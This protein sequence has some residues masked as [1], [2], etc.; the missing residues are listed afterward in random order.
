MAG[1]LDGIRIL[2]FSQMMMGPW[3]TQLLGDLGADVIKVERP[4][5]GEWER[6]LAAM[7]ELLEGD[8]PFFLAMNRNKRS[9]TLNLKHPVARQVI[10][11]LIPEIDIVVENFRPGV[12]DR[13]GYGYERL[14]EINPRLIYCSASG[15]GS[16]GPYVDRPGQD[17]LIQALSGIAAHTGP[18]TEPPTPTGTS[19]CDAMASMMVSTGVLA[20]LQ[21]RERTGQGQKVEVD[22]LSTA[23]AIQCQEAVAYLNGMPRWERSAAGIAQ[24]WIAAPYGIYATSDSFLALAMNPLGVLGELLELP[25]VAEYEGDAGRAYSDRD[26]IRRLLEVRLLERTTDDWLT[27]LAT[28]DVWCAPVKDFDGVFSDPQVQAVEM[29][30]TVEHP[31]I[32]ELKVIRTPLSFSQTPPSIRRPPPLVGEHSEEILHELGYEDDAIAAMHDEGVW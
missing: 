8:S 9:L 7:G 22:L 31:R 5:V 30:A 1:A 3:A 6:S 15:Y 14:A 2:D 32:G 12:L 10:D 20:A 19:I 24:P 29:V 16:T 11:K 18:A 25:E 28:R 26:R 17:L 13:L 21:S 4:G 23:I 27:L